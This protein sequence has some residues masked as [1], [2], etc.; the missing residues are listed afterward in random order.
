MAA[1]RPLASVVIDMATGDLAEVS[2]SIR[3]QYRGSEPGGGWTFERRRYG[4]YA[5]NASDPDIDAVVVDD[6]R[7][8]DV[9]G[10]LQEM[11]AMFGLRPARIYLDDRELESSLQP[12]LE[13]NG[14]Q[15]TTELQYLTHFGPCPSGTALPGLSVREA[16]TEAELR[17][18][19]IARL[20]ALGDSDATPNEEEV[21]ANL[22]GRISSLGSCRYLIGW[23]GDEPA[24]LVGWYEGLD[25]LIF[26]L[27][28]RLPY[29]RRG[30]ARHLLTCLIEETQES[31]EYRSLTIFTNPDDGPIAFYRDM[32]FT[33]EVYWQARYRYDPQDALP[34]S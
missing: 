10:L 24:T 31:P 15:R 19:E 6:I 5:Q 13:A 18:Y 4:V 2:D 34:R 21:T 23:L 25:R 7:A 17:A 30:L 29:R 11:R 9:P 16:T 12:A 3:A 1:V 8:I 28:T 32:G 33:G 22:R 14:C 20:K 27:A 26:N